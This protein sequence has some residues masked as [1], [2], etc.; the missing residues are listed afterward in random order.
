MRLLLAPRRT[1]SERA[2]GREH[3]ARCSDCW[4]VLALL[5]ELA[6]GVPPAEA[7][8]MAGLFGCALVQEELYLM[9]GLDAPAL[10]A[11]HPAA[12]QHL[13]WCVACRERF[14]ELAAVE[15]V[16]ARGEIPP[17][18]ATAPRW[19]AVAAQAGETVREAVGR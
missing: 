7:D 12:A 15:G 5:H 11:A 16:A 19:Q 6:T 3:A 13:G 18:L 10:R 17:L 9:T 1:E 8:R 14:A 4:A 2:P